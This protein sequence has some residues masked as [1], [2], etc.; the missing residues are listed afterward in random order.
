MALFFKKKGDV[1][2]VDLADFQRR[3]LFRPKS[4]PK[5][6]IT[7]TDSQGYADLSATTPLTSSTN[8]NSSNTQQS[9]SGS[10]MF[11]WFSNMGK[12]NSQT[13]NNNSSPTASSSEYGSTTS[14]SQGSD[15]NLK[16]KI[17]DLEFKMENMSRKINNFLERLELIEK[18]INR[19]EGR[20]SY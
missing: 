7:P 16:N 5:K 14:I 11:D 10:G 13:E 12:S 6:T 15:S 1:G 8:T 9:S 2:V 4:V 20:G 3:G 19:L 17:D 18:K